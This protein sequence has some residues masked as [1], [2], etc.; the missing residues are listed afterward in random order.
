MTSICN[1]VDLL[2]TELYHVVLPP[3][4]APEAWSVVFVIDGANIQCWVLDRYNIQLLW[5]K[6]KQT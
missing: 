6:L 4:P 1:M 3:T 5:G 2:G